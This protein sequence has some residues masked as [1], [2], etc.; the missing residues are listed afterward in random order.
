MHSAYRQAKKFKLDEDLEVHDQFTSSAKAHIRRGYNDY[1]KGLWSSQS[2]PLFRFLRSKVSQRWDS[3]FSQAIARCNANTADTAYKLREMLDYTVEKEC[4]MV[5]GV[6]YDKPRWGYKS[7]V[8][9]LYVHPV[10][11]ILCHANRQRYT[12]QR[13]ERTEVDGKNGVTFDVYNLKQRQ[14]VRGEWEEVIVKVWMKST[15]YRHFV[16]ERWWDTTDRDE[17]GFSKEKYKEYY[18]TRYK[19]AT[20]SKKEIR[21][22]NLNK[23]K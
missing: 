19:T 23:G 20:A 17:K 10:T 18:E 14:H 13:R 22:N 5:D 11:G 1:H 12:S 3:V 21:D 15:P 2:K 7:T 6:V 4:T 8:N 9:G 16:R